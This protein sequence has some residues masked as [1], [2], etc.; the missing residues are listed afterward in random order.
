MYNFSIRVAQN[1]NARITVRHKGK[2]YFRLGGYDMF[3]LTILSRQF[4]LW[5]AALLTLTGAFGQTMG[6][7]TITGTVTDAT[8]GVIVG[9]QI[10]ATN[11]D[12][13]IARSTVT[14]AS[15]A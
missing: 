9:V 6:T 11:L 8:G 12:T 13:G 5:C 1:G 7:G 4:L 3:P 14:N 10:T 2:S 15:G